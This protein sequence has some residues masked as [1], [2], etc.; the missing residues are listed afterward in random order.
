[1][2]G[3]PPHS[4]RKPQISS[5]VSPLHSLACLSPPHEFRSNT[6]SGA[7]LWGE[8][9]SHHQRVKSKGKPVSEAGLTPAATNPVLKFVPTA[10]RPQGLF[11]SL[12]FPSKFKNNHNF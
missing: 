8:S 9:D 2:G 10:Q 5:K 4:G 1:M 12:L 11:I 7:G 3:C 6:G